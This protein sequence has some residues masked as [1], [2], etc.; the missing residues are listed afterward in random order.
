MMKPDV[1]T[2][3]QDLRNLEWTRIRK[4]SGTAGSLLK[5]QS[6]GSNGRIYYKLSGYDSLNQISGHESVNEIIA[7]RLLSILGIEH[8]S[9]QLIHSMV[10]IDKTEH[11]T[12]LCASEDF[13]EP[14]D[15]KMPLDDYYDLHKEKDESPMSFC[16]RMGWES[17]IYEMLVVDYLILNR[18]RHGAN[19]EILLNK[20]T[21]TVR[22]APLFD[23]GLSLMCTCLNEDAV[24]K[25][26]ILGDY[27]V[28]SFVGSRSAYENLSLIPANKRPQLRALEER[29]RELL[30]KD[31]EGAL[32][33]KHL[34][35]I[36]DMIWQRWRVYESL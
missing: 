5:S 18:D 19:I 6:L 26:D 22:P 12:W 16:I 3:L 8:L 1:I 30:L 21:G 31:L 34:E 25:F 29:D 33:R 28:Q 10:E 11:E 17:Y 32:S 15:S 4:S 27:A 23:H 24:E 7:D 20:R 14:G 2:E 36:W 9:Y 13:K 35:K